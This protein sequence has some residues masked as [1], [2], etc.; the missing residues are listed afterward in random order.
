MFTWVNGTHEFFFWLCFWRDQA[1]TPS[2]SKHS[3]TLTVNY[4]LSNTTADIHYSKAGRKCVRSNLQRD[5]SHYGLMLLWQ[6]EAKQTCAL[7]TL[8]TQTKWTLAP[9]D[10]SST[11]KPWWGHGEEKGEYQSNISNIPLLRSTQSDD[12]RVFIY[13]MELLCIQKC[14]YWVLLSGSLGQRWGAHSL[15]LDTPLNQT[16]LLKGL[17]LVVDLG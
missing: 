15:S 7:T 14:P 8:L 12:R 2:C 9:S 3:L 1:A 16:L 13:M 10:L 11:V 17:S 5:Q 4:R 6:L